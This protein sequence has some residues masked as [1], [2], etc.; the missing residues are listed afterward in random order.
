MTAGV[1]AS[2]DVDTIVALH[3]RILLLLLIPLL[4]LSFTGSP[5]GVNTRD[6]ACLRTE[7]QRTSKRTPFQSRLGV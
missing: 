2:E 4:H 3:T 1:I 5:A 7:F 6:I